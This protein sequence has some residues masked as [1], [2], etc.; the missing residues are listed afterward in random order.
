MAFPTL[1]KGMKDFIPTEMKQRP[2]QLKFTYYKFGAKVLFSFI[3]VAQF[4]YDLLYL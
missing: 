1:L 3:P 2:K 4:I